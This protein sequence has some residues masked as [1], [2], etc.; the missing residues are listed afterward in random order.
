MCIPCPRA[1]VVGGSSGVLSII[2]S[3]ITPFPSYN[4]RNILIIKQ[5]Y[6]RFQ[7]YVRGSLSKYVFIAG[8]PAQ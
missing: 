5:K 6:F 7:S 8:I 3:H 2:S 4:M 1:R